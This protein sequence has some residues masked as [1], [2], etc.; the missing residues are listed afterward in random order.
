MISGQLNSNFTVAP[1][2][3][4]FSNDSSEIA[5]VSSFQRRAG[6]KCCCHC[7]LFEALVQCQGFRIIIVEDGTMYRNG[8][9]VNDSNKKVG[10]E[11]KMVTF[12]RLLTLHYVSYSNRGKL[13]RYFYFVARVSFASFANIIRYFLTYLLT[14]P[15]S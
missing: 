3:N 6:C 1:Y 2:T 10:R 8:T 15:S 7:F 13:S 14:F 4:T 5:N 12:L 9:D 11:W